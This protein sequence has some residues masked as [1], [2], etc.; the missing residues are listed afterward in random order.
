MKITALTIGVIL[1][2]RIVKVD[3]NETTEQY[4]IKDLESLLKL[5]AKYTALL[6]EINSTYHSRPHNTANNMEFEK[7]FQKVLIGLNSTAYD[8]VDKID[9]YTDFTVYN[10]MR[11]ELEREISKTLQV[12]K[13]LLKLK[14]LVPQCRTFFMDQQVQLTASIS[15]SNFAKMIIL[16][17]P[18]NECES[19]ELNRITYPATKAT[20]APTTTPKPINYD[21][22]LL[23]ILK[24]YN[25]RPWGNRKYVEFDEQIWQV[26]MA[27]NKDDNNYKNETLNK[28][29]EYDKDRAQLDKAL[30]LRIGKFKKRIAVEP[31]NDCKGN[32]LYINKQ[33]S[34]AMFETIEKKRKILLTSNY[35]Q[36]CVKTEKVNHNIIV[37]NI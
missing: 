8:L 2:A 35:V 32:L 37:V 29:L 15:Q 31:N 11:L 9:I 14:N 23:E 13:N 3:G 33:F 28:F 34:R 12:A 16:N 1:L 30:A 6:Q 18:S 27:T 17:N 22:L 36:A 20:T 26:F 10:Q 25:K 4:E 19:V 5:D 21:S 7:F 24:K